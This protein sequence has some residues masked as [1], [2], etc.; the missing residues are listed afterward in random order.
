[1]LEAVADLR[2]NL[3]RCGSGLIVKVGKPEIIFEEIAQ[4]MDIK[5]GVINIVCQEEICSEELSINEAVS[6]RLTSQDIKFN[7]H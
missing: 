4:Q 1:M 7:L 6:S 5:S 3:K 2:H